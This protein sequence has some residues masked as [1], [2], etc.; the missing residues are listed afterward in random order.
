MLGLSPTHILAR[1]RIDLDAIA[2]NWR[3]LDAMS[4][5]TTQTAGVIKAD[6][7]GLG[8]APVGR[9]LA[10][11]GV[12]TFFVALPSEGAILRDAIGDAADWIRLGRSPIMLAGG[13]EATIMPLGIGGFAGIYLGADARDDVDGALH[14]IGAIGRG[15]GLAIVRHVAENHGG[16]VLVESKP[17]DGSTFTIELPRL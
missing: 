13:A 7:Y 10:S 12:R 9:K 2:E 14:R 16:R 1:P 5:A 3:R 4:A 11:I 8:T 17:G 6:A 15:L